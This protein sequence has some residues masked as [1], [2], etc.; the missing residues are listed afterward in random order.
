MSLP[1]CPFDPAPISM[2]PSETEEAASDHE[3]DLEDDPD[4]LDDQDEA[5]DQ[6]N[7]EEEEEEEEECTCGEGPLASCWKCVP[8]TSAASTASAAVATAVTDPEFGDSST[9]P[10]SSSK[11]STHIPV[12]VVAAVVAGENIDEIVQDHDNF[13]TDENEDSLD[14]LALASGSVSIS[15]YR[16]D[17]EDSIEDESSLFGGAKR[18]NLDETDRVS[19]SEPIV[20]KKKKTS[21]GSSNCFELHWNN[22]KELQ[23][24]EKSSQNETSKSTTTTR[25]T[26]AELQQQLLQHQHQQQQQ[27]QQQVFMAG[28]HNLEHEVCSPQPAAPVN[29]STPTCSKAF[30][31]DE[32][33]EQ[34]PPPSAA[35]VSWIET[36]SRWSH[37]DKIVAIDQL[38][39]ACHPTQVRHMMTVIEPQF[40]RDFISLLPK[41]VMFI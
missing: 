31:E 29:C 2:C 33:S 18:K 4:D 37:G 22:D 5:D 30:L 14:S 1:S 10:R 23:R 3:D 20:K 15:L 34:L 9:V 21:Q 24:Q 27:Q 8:S 38:I 35:V 16:P 12:A 11:I 6:D 13:G 32:E 26:V 28:D 7:Q 36:F 40:Q 25:P 39:S 41:E 19:D 17:S